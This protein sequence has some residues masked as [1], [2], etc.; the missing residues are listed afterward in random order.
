MVV[1]AETDNLTRSIEATRAELRQAGDA[2]NAVFISSTRLVDGYQTEARVRQFTFAVDEPP[3]LGGTDTGPNP[4]ELV[5]AALGTCQEIVYATYA[6]LLN[7]PIEDVRI[8]VTGSLDPRGFFGVADVKAGFSDVQYEVQIASSASADQVALL[9]DTV[10]RHCPVLDI[11]E[12]PI[13]VTGSYTLNGDTVTPR[14]GVAV[15]P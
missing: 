12:R 11:L 14:P 2:A 8:R 1:K 13:S 6:R 10:N 7:I 15:L 5:A 3:S 4:A 9:I